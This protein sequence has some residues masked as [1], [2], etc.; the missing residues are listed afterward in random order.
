[1]YNKPLYEK[2]LIGKA[3]LVTYYTY[4]EDGLVFSHQRQLGQFEYRPVNNTAANANPYH[5]ELGRFT[6][7]DKAV[8]ISGCQKAM[9][10]AKKAE[11]ARTKLNKCALETEGSLAWAKNVQRGLLPAGS[12][13]CNLYVYEMGR[14]AGMHMPARKSSTK[15][16]CYPFTAGEWA[17]PKFK[18][19]GWK[20]IPISMLQDGDIIA[21]TDTRFSTLRYLSG[22][23]RRGTGHV[24]IVVRKEGR[25]MTAS[26]SS[27]ANPSGMIVVNDFGF[28]KTNLKKGIWTARRYVGPENH[29]P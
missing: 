6:T 13:K 7:A 19:D 11:E 18:I 10:V 14:L 20:I 27:D 21:K 16:I 22:R 8:T 26:A 5:D 12:F 15:S 4:G 25:L 2:V 17:D 29:Y 9:L 1:M 24:G 3:R 28:N 23:A